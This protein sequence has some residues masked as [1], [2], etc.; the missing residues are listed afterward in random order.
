MNFE[1]IESLN[2]Q[3]GDQVAMFG[4][5]R[6]VRAATWTLATKELE[7]ASHNVF[8]LN[9]RNEVI[10]QVR[11]V[12]NITRMPWDQLHVRAKAKYSEG[13]PDGAY[14]AMGYLD[15]FT[16]MNLDERNAIDP[17]P[18]GVWRSGCVIY[19]LT[20][21]W[22]YVLDPETGVATCTGDQVK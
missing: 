20:H 8:R 4:E 22:S 18:K 2:I 7:I 1:T 15:P 9:A 19:L 6:L 12:E 11:R 16:S 13:S 3:V 5:D 10:W 17:E 21:W 14:T